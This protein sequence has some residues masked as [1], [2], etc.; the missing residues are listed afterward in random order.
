MKSDT[1]EKYNQLKKQSEE[2]KQRASEAQGALNQI[3]KQLKKDFDCDTLEQAE[4][5][6]KRLRW[7]GK[8]LQEKF[9]KELDEF[10]R[11]HRQQINR[12]STEG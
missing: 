11:Q 4:T 6:L 7:Q 3:M 8:Q 9:D 10:E 2:A 12:D 1:L 5:K